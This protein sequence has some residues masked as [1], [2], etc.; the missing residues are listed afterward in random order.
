MP[1]KDKGIKGKPSASS[2]LSGGLPKLTGGTGSHSK[3]IMFYN[4]SLK[5]WESPMREKKEKTAT[6]GPDRLTEFQGF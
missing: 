1:S 3:M 5:E 2:K 4:R 6:L